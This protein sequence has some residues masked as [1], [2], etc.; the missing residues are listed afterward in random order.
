MR[1]WVYLMQ[2][3]LNPNREKPDLLRDVY[4]HA[5]KQAEEICLATAYLTDWDASHRL[6]PKCKRLTFLVGTDFGLTRKAAMLGVLKW[7]PKSTPFSF[8]GAVPPQ[9][10]GFHPK[11]IAWKEFS[12][13]H[14][15]MIGSSNLS[16]AAFSDNFEANVLTPISSTEFARICKWVDSFSEGS[17]P[18]PISPDWIKHHYKEAK[19]GSKAGSP[20]SFI[21][22]C[23]TYQVDVVARNRFVITAKSKPVLLR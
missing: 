3:F 19:L 7:I 18:V 10:G 17:S 11:M 5:F 23:L 12:G 2:I 14:Y 21:L 16:R 6:N 13:K 4:R 8:F 22:V 20:R 1:V 9:K 15:C